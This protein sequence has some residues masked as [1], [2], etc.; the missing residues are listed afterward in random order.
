MKCQKAASSLNNLHA[1]KQFCTAFV[2][3]CPTE[4]K[5]LNWK[6]SY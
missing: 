5:S 1:Y 4:N 2:A 3:F 6:D